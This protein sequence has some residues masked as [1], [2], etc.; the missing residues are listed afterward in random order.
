M[1]LLNNVLGFGRKIKQ[2]VKKRS[3]D[4]FDSLNRQVVQPIKSFG[5]KSNNVVQ[6][7]GNAI[8][9]KGIDYLFKKPTQVASRIGALGAP[10]I[11]KPVKIAQKS[12]S[13]SFFNKNSAQGR[14]ATV[15]RASLQKPAS[16]NV[17]EILKPK[18]TNI[19]DSPIVRAVKDRSIKPLT[20]SFFTKEG[21]KSAVRGAG[22]SAS[23]PFNAIGATSELSTFGSKVLKEIASSKSA[24]F[25]ASALKGM[26]KDDIIPTLSRKLAS[27]SKSSEVKTVIEEAKKAKPLTEIL[28]KKPEVGQKMPEAHK[29]A[30]M[31]RINKKGYTSEDVTPTG[32]GPDAPV[33]KRGQKNYKMMTNTGVSETIGK[34]VKIV[35]GV[36]TF[37]RKENGV[38][39][40]SEASSGRFLAD[41][42]TIK[43]AVSESRR[44]IDGVGED[45]FK[46]LI[47]D[48]QLPQSKVKTPKAEKKTKYYDPSKPFE[49]GKNDP[50]EDPSMYYPDDTK[51]MQGL[52]EI[53][54]PNK[55]PE[56]GVKIY[57]YIKDGVA[58]LDSI[59]IAKSKQGGGLGT[60]YVEEFEQWAR[61]NGAKKIEID[62]YKNSTGFWEKKGFELE[63]DFP[64]DGGVK[65]SFKYGSK[66]LEQ[67]KES[68]RAVIDKFI[69]EKG[70][71]P[72]VAGI[73]PRW[74]Y[75]ENGVP[76][77]VP[78]D[79][80]L[81]LDKADFRT[82]ENAKVTKTSN[83]LYHTTSVESLDSIRK[84]GLTAGNKPRFEG[85]SSKNNISF[86]ANEEGASYYGKDGD[87]M[88]RTKTSYKPDDLD[89]DPLAG[90]EGTYITKKNIP[91]Q[92]LEVKVNGKWEPLIKNPNITIDQPTPGPNRFERAQGLTPEGAKIE[93]DAFKKIEAN[94]E[95]LMQEYLEN[96]S[97]Q[98]KNISNTDE[99]R[100]LFK[101]VGYAGHNAADVQEPAS[102]MGKKVWN[103]LLENEGPATIYAGG[104]GSG[105]SSAIKGL[106][107]ETLSGSSAILDG[108]LSSMNSALKRIDEAAKAGKKTNLIY[109]YRDPID[110]LVNGVISRMKNNADEGGRIV[111][112]H[113]VAQNH[114]GSWK[115]IDD[116]YQTAVAAGEGKTDMFNFVNNSL[117][118]NKARL[119]DYNEFK[120]IQYPEDLE[121]QMVKAVEDAFSRGEL[122]DIQRAKLL[123]GSGGNMPPKAPPINNPMP[124]FPEGNDKMANLGINTNHLNIGDESKGIVNQTM[125]E[126]KPTLENTVGKVMGKEE[127]EKAAQATAQTLKRTLSR[128][129]VLDIGARAQNLRQEIAV[130]A[131]KGTITPELIDALKRDKEFSSGTARLL[132]Q[133]SID[134]DPIEKNPMLQMVELVNAKVN[135]LDAVL[136]AAKGVD[137]NDAN[138]SA[139][140]YR[141]FIK[142][143]MGDWIDLLRYNSMLTS[144]L[145]HIVNISSNLVNSGAIAPLEKTVAGGIDFFGSMVTG[146]ERSQFAMEGVQ[147]LGGYIK[148]VG[149]AAQRFADV[150]T[151]KVAQTNLDTRHIPLAPGSKA[152]AALSVPLKLLEGMDQFFTVLTEGGE[153]ASLNYRQAKGIKVNNLEGQVADK[154]AYRIYRQD[155]HADEQGQLLDAVDYVTGLV[156]KARNSENAIVSNIA[157]WTIPFIKTPTNIF[158]QGLEYSPVGF[159]TVIGAK[160]KTDQLAKAVIGSAVFSGAAMLLGSD[161]LTWAM[162]IGQKEKDAFL[163]AGKQPYSVKI[164]DKYFS[165]QKLPPELSFSLALV[166]AIDDTQKNSKLSDDTVDQILTA[167]AK[168]GQFLSDQSYAKNMGDLLTAAKGGESGITRLLSN[169]PQQMV[170][171]RALGG[172]L[173]RIVDD[174]QRTIDPKL[175]FIDKQVQLLMQ[176]IPGLRDNTP[177]RV[178]QFGNEIKQS[179]NLANAVSPVRMSTERPEEAAAYNRMMGDKLTASEKKQAKDMLMNGGDLSDME[180]KSPELAELG[181]AGNY[182]YAYDLEKYTK[183]NSESGIKRYTFE[184]DKAKVARD[185]ME[186]TATYKDL[187]DEIKP[188]IYKAMGLD[189]QDVEYDYMS[190]QPSDAVSQYLMEEMSAAD[191][192]HNAVIQA[193]INGRRASISGKM[194]VANAVVDD[195]YKNGIISKTEATALKKVKLG[196][197]GENQS[198]PASGGGSKK[199]KLSALVTALKNVPKIGNYNMDSSQGKGGTDFSIPKPSQADTN[200][201]TKVQKIAPI[202]LEQIFAGSQSNPMAGTNISQAKSIVANSGGGAPGTGLK[203]SKSF[204]RGR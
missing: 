81:L 133:R 98:N 23:D 71:R 113:V 149:E 53:G 33:L 204:Y 127:V 104:S 157:K 19:G 152:E 131:E 118:K 198:A 185:I 163:A 112:V 64:I 141:Q 28:A 97:G 15:K 105:K 101:D 66:S 203:L 116:L 134:V 115:V 94:E 72:Y 77:E 31:E 110:S 48:N 78:K 188:E 95:A 176:N 129:E 136:E 126:L 7:T 45:G 22:N 202:S 62:A 170:P 124:A 41:G 75:K 199:K 155:L 32:F 8:G 5:I 90:G 86:S 73:P 100:K 156:M 103:R 186:G 18:E 107:P 153:R 168:Y 40:V 108:N 96:Y 13:E 68:G 192:D 187:P 201:E 169:Y 84:S 69:A 171:Y 200:L 29:Q 4:E 12:W 76:T 172:W 173:A 24:K 161:R 35:D 140:F 151:G 142:P 91:P 50:F 158:K 17:R 10:A 80:S 196:K 37:V 56:K 178:D 99:A 138:Q 21:L 46:K 135:D 87:V 38:W 117:G 114:I 190:N 83:N 47:A 143:K 191:L 193:L 85:V 59:E 147:H 74:F 165:Y 159:G 67:P 183:G 42:N 52:K 51:P 79:I 11:T 180:G 25:I 102:Y 164:G 197:N 111:P 177:A 43:E 14:V 179:D 26:V 2:Y 61:D 139:I 54:Y 122:T 55:E 175:G 65:Q 39:V 144:P 123:E 130:L 109:V 150:M 1:D 106:M 89:I 6:K 137:F 16:L 70:G 93:E 162:P 189:Q 167:V 174:T 128:E 36:E 166:A 49:V 9:N 30:I 20:S 119:M 194:M 154:A 3:N 82:L 44:R 92:E 60:K 58:K 148:S 146:K 125:D 181:E 132:Q 27:V 160:N 145:T 88:I 120:Q 184:T 121:A 195:L 63:K 34:P 182:I 57:G